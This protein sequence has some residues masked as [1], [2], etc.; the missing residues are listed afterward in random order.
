MGTKHSQGR[1]EINLYLSFKY[2]MLH[3]WQGLEM[4]ILSSS[5][6]P[7]YAL[8]FC[9]M[10]NGGALLHLDKC[11]HLSLVFLS[12]KSTL[13]F[14]TLPHAH[15]TLFFVHFRLALWLMR[16][17]KRIL[18]NRKHKNI[19]IQTGKNLDL[20]AA[21]SSDWFGFSSCGDTANK[22]IWLPFGYCP[23]LY[24]TRCFVLEK[25][26]LVIVLCGN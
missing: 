3:I 13:C 12:L 14:V 4:H 17:K 7:S 1:Q 15:G 10:H 24:H 20:S 26:A 2:F 19:L 11:C 22:T 21:C 8:P 25:D 16:I 5:V 9:Q 6:S 18:P 23:T